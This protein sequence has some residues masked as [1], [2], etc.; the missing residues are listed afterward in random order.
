MEGD[1][2][3]EILEDQSSVM[4]KEKSHL[5]EIELPVIF[6]SDTAYIHKTI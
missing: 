2:S 4:F 6:F 1:L 5:G 3:K